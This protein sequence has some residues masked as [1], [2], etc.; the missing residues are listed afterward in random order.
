[1]SIKAPL[2]KLAKALTNNPR[3]TA[4]IVFLLNL[5]FAVFM[6]TVNVYAAEAGQATELSAKGL[7]LIGAGI[8]IGGACIGAGIAV[9][10]ATSAG[11]A[12]IVERPG[13]AIWILIFAGLGEGIA[14]WGFA[15][16]IM[17]LGAL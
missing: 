15:I 7:G 4:L 8:A 13:V 3:R 12:A 10:G 5:A 1:V 11:A 9:Y 14:I 6:L 2:H 16:A 17:I